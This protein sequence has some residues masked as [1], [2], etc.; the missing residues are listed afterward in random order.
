[1]DSYVVYKELLINKLR[2]IA[3]GFLSSCG[4]GKP[5][6]CLLPF[7]VFTRRM[8]AKRQGKMCKLFINSS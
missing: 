1:M 4:G 5:R 6:E 7:K 2:K 8:A 3:A